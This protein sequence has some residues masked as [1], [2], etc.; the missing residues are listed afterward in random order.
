MLGSGSQPGGYKEVGGRG[1]ARQPTTI[2]QDK[3]SD[4]TKYDTRQWLLY[5]DEL[6]FRF[7][8]V[9]ALVVGI[10]ALNSI[11][12]TQTLLE[13]S[14]PLLSTSDQLALTAELIVR[15]AQI[16][17]LQTSDES[18]FRTGLLCA[19]IQEMFQANG[20]GVRDLLKVCGEMELRCASAVH[21]EIRKSD[22]SRFEAGQCY[23]TVNVEGVE[24]SICLPE[25]NIRK[26]TIESTGL[27]PQ[28][29]ETGFPPHSVPFSATFQGGEIPP[30]MSSSFNLFGDYFYSN[31]QLGPTTLPLER[32]LAV[33][34]LNGIFI[35][36]TFNTQ[37][38]EDTISDVFGGGPAVAPSSALAND[39]VAFISLNTETST[40]VDGSSGTFGKITSVLESSSFSG[41]GDIY[42][43]N[44]MVVLSGPEDVNGWDIAGGLQSATARPTITQEII[45]EATVNGDFL[46]EA[47]GQVHTFVQSTT[48]K[49]FF[50]SGITRPKAG[51]IS[52]RLALR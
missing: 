43:D 31:P 11:N 22:S 32:T 25:Q 4:L 41:V 2:S 15:D 6:A 12:D 46:F 47:P 20:R 8:A 35:S 45:R 10:L 39:G 36:Y 51:S 30:F 3:Y 19:V 37:W 29:I 13:R 28:R 14:L 17:H 34:D 9:A 42:V 7:M 49:R 27:L 18:C 33:N 52:G 38:N 40:T 44:E 1:E 26:P 21:K 50:F 5:F 24:F 48:G 23:D 16:R